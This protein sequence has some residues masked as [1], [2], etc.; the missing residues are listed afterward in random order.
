MNGDNEQMTD[1]IR[2][3]FN[4]RQMNFRRNPVGTEAIRHRILP[5]RGTAR[6]SKKLSFYIE[7]KVLKHNK[8]FLPL[9]I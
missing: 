7:A 2:M 9:S 1:K 6:R 3:N 5:E 8:N 4:D